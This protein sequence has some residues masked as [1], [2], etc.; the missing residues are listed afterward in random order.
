MEP[1]SHIVWAKHKTRKLKLENNE[2]AYNVA[3]VYNISQPIHIT[4]TEMMSE[5]EYNRRMLHVDDLRY[6]AIVYLWII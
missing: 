6:E 3:H 4:D 1:T 2:A 5:R